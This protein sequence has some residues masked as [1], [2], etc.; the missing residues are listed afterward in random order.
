MDRYGLIHQIDPKGEGELKRN[1]DEMKHLRERIP[2]R[3]APLSP[4]VISGLIGMVDGLAMLWSGLFVFVLHVGWTAEKLPPYLSTLALAVLLTIGTFYFANLY[5]F[6]AIT[7]PGDQIKKI[8]VI[9]AIVFLCLVTLGYA[10]SIGHTFSRIWAFSTFLSS[11]VLIYIGRTVGYYV[12][13]KWA[14]SG[15]LSRNIVIVGAG[16]QAKKLLERLDRIYEPWNVVV[17]V[18]DDRV[19]RTGPKV[20]GYPV[21]GTVDD[22]FT[23]AREHRVDDVIVSLPWSAEKRM[24]EIV[25]KLKELPVHIRLGSDMAGFMYPRG[26]YSVLGGVTTMDVVSKPLSGWKVVVKYL[27]DKILASL[28]LILFSPLM[29]LIALAVRLESGGP[30]LFR[31]PRYGFN[32]Q[33]FSVYKFRTMYNGRSNGTG[34]PDV[35]WDDP[36]VTRLGRLLRRTR[37][38]ELPQLFNVLG[39]TMSLV[40]PR[41]HEVAHNE[42]YGKPVGGYF[43]RHRV[44]P[45][46]TGWAQ[47]DGLAGEWNSPERMKARV[48][49]DIYYIEHWSLFLDLQIMLKTI[50]IVYFRKRVH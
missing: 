16:P 25:S 46:I 7:H 27:E 45:G 23:Y 15:W 1:A 22:L 5:K 41:P 29:A 48:D 34:A 12:L 43:S 44:K 47:I 3:T 37:L 21:L 50:Y 17:G 11:V 19:N 10:L 30:I 49:H 6:E 38:D 35:R 2:A 31:Q 24:P 14:E 18:F 9:C 36:R 28:L 33:V 26:S 4:S 20:M 40:G 8:A 13:R 32:N 39:G 42:A